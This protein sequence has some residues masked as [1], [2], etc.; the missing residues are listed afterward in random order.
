MGTREGLMHIQL[1]CWERGEMHVGGMSLAV[2]FAK[3]KLWFVISLVK[4]RSILY[5]KEIFCAYIYSGFVLKL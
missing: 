4:A 2:I 1:D 3:R 5:Q